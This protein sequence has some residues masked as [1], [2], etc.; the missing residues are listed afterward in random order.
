[1]NG[2]DSW[3]AWAI[4]AIAALAAAAVPWLVRRDERQAA[5]LERVR[6]EAADGIKMVLEAV[7]RAESASTLQHKELRELVSDRL[8][9]VYEKIAE[10]GR[11]SRKRYEGVREDIHRIDRRLTAVVAMSGKT[12]EVNDASGE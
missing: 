6:A 10:D 2:T 4:G 1:M 7:N 9:K 12:Q 8:A 3:L 11:D 5:E